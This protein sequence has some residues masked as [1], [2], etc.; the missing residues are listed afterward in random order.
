MTIK[1]IK[2]PYV[3]SFSTFS[4][5]W[6]VTYRYLIQDEIKFSFI[7]TARDREIAKEIA[8]LLNKATSVL[9]SETC[10]AHPR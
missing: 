10:G 4:K 1:Q 9:S 2:N 5:T 6:M 3:I 8:S 7:C